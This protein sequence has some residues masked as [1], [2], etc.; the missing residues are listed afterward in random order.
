MLIYWNIKIELK[1][2][3]N[4]RVTLTVVYKIYW[5]DILKL[6]ILKYKKYFDILKYSIELN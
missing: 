5:N 4:S 6:L 3:I 1:S 2:K